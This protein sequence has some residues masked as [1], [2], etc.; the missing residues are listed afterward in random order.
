[1]KLTLSI[2]IPTHKRPHILRRCLEHIEKQTVTGQL[3]VIVV[4]DGPDDMARRVLEDK[5]WAMPVKFFEIPKSQQGV[6]RN[7][8]VSEASGEFILFIGDDIFLAPDACEKH[9]AAHV[10]QYHDLQY[11][12]LG[13]TTWDPAC[14]ITPVMKWL[15]KSGWQFGYPFIRRY[16]GNFL[17]DHLQQRFTYTSHISL[18][19]KIAKKFAF[20]EDVTFYGWEDIEWGWR[21]RNADI[22]LFYESAAT[23]LHHHRIMMED[24][25]K[26]M[27][28]LGQ[29]AVIMDRL[30]P[31]MNLTPTGRK[32]M[33]YRAAA[34]LPGMRGMHTRA[35][36]RG[37]G[38]A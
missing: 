38:S 28:T 5:G 27:E 30:A 6:A 32:L 10:S 2:V 37:V 14:G 34:L 31:G 15:E 22:K 20:R 16:G 7:K 36:L 1:V 19:T 25:L 24:S 35:F 8:G 11:A 17:P 9:L 21:L 29:S 4:S 18:P 12:V 3:E 33:K 13:F 26:R 23:A